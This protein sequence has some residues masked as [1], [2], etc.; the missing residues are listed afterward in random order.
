VNENVDCRVFEEQ[1][2]GLVAGELTDDGVR[3]LRA[4]ALECPDC[5]MLLKV[6]EHL[7]LPSLEELATSVPQ[8]HLDSMWSAVATGVKWDPIA[9]RSAGRPKHRLGWIIPALAAA[10]VALLFST[11]FLFSELRQSASRET[12]LAERMGDLEQ[13]LADLGART[14][15]I[16]RTGRLA[17]AGRRSA[18]VVDFLLTGKESLTVADLQA[19][20]DRYPSDMIV[21]EAS[22]VEDLTTSNTP[23]PPEFRE[24]LSLIAEAHSDRGGHQGV[25]A[26]DLKEWLE[27]SD[28]PPDLV[29]PKAHILELLSRTS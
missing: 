15:W 7:F 3:N 18:R 16:E 25:R 2:D 21:L 13:G 17:S 19:L 4:H 8:E 20:L 29:L 11:G 9:Q 10:S 28:L 24:V 12:A 5:A 23:P 26:G 6:H 22:R 14:D 27:E 1:L